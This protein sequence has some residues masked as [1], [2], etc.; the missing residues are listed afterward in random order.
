MINFFMLF[1]LGKLS[2]FLLNQTMVNNKKW[3]IKEKQ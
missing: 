2:I 3:L 1:G